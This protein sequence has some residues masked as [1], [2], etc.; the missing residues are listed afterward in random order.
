MPSGDVTS[1][2]TLLLTAASAAA[3]DR[4]FRRLAVTEFS[5]LRYSHGFVFQHLVLGSITIGTLAERLGITQQGASKVVAELERMG[6]VRR[7][8]AAHDQRVRL[9]ELTERGI[10]AVQAKRRA[11]AE[12]SAELLGLLGAGAGQFVATLHQLAKSSGGLDR[13]TSRR[14]RQ[15]RASLAREAQ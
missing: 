1:D 2:L 12:V 14:L 6:Y 7:T 9:V 13:L 8:I 3:D 5:D 10:A 11:R 15:D 4:V